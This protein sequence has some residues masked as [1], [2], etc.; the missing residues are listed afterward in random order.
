MVPYG[1]DL[2]DRQRAARRGF[3]R[4]VTAAYFCWWRALT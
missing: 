1:T 4:W 3:P 2:P